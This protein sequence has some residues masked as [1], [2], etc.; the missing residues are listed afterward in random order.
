MAH[1]IALTRESV[2]DVLD[3]GWTDGTA[4]ADSALGV[5]H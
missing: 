4:P 5:G 3:G 2:L 1:Y